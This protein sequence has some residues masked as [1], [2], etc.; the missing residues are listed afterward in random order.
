MR[1]LV[2]EALKRVGINESDVAVRWDETL[3]CYVIYVRPGER[4]TEHER[5]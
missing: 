4:R 3:G 1:E 2:V 5:D